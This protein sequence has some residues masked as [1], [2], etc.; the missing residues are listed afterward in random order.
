MNRM[1]LSLVPLLAALVLAGC[2]ALPPSV[3]TELPPTPT[4]WKAPSGW[5]TAA[6]AATLARGDWWKAFADT[7]LND[8]IERAARGNSELRV[9][10]ARLAQ[11][12]ALVR[13]SRA[14]QLPQL[15]A[16]AS[17][18]RSRGVGSS[19]ALGARLDYELDLAGRLALAS[20]AARL[21][22]ASREALLQSTRLLVQA[23]VAQT[24]FALRALDAERRL[25]S[26]TAQ[27]Y[28]DALRLTERRVAAGEIAELDLAR[29][30]G[31]LA[32]TEAEGL[33]LDRQRA[34]L[35]NALALLVGESASSFRL[36]RAELRDQDWQ[37]AAPVV[38][39]GLPSTLLARR[40]DVAAAQQ[41]LLAA[42]AR[43][44]IA[45]RAWFPD[46]VLTG[47]AGLASADLG[48]LLRSGARAWGVGALL[49]LPLFDGGRRDAARAGAQAQLE[50]A[51]AEHRQQVLVAFKDVED[52]LS[53][54]AL[55]AEQQ[56]AQ[57]EAV[58]AAERA[59][60]LSATR[61]RNGLV[62]QLELLDAQRNELGQRRAA[63][64][65]QAAQK[66]SAVGLIRA[67]GGGWQS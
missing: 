29:A 13:T 58:A 56:R 38:P 49:S 9:A 33:A 26:D 42:Q 54:L 41:A 63:L 27:S 11:A 51:A 7:T 1:R 66:H 31:E 4:E 47:S 37:A 3:P 19:F 61:Y 32:A 23:E 60:M 15:Q 45:A 24:Y 55:L 59:R 35:E 67:L 52:Q 65:V 10:A 14:A 5:T 16:G 53:A 40:P 64:R 62:S 6:P 25:V 39:A 28:R 48:D 30:R 36:D 44:G 43:A 18:E 57:G 34:A 17:A 20:D 22:S 2:A 50:Q 46:L 8:L 21:D 12:Q